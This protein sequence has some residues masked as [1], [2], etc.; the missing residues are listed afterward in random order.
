MEGVSVLKHKT[1]AL[2]S[3]ISKKVRS[4]VKPPP[5]SIAKESNEA[6]LLQKRETVTAID[7]DKDIDDGTARIVPKTATDGRH[8]N[9]LLLKINFSRALDNTQI[10]DDN[11]WSRFLNW[12]SR[13]GDK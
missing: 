10:R 13:R 4:S 8:Q 9:V 6:E 2:F 3:R 7:N 1:V 11:W 12:F 5:D